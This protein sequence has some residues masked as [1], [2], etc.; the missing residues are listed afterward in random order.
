M[1]SPAYT[2]GGIA[3][4]IGEDGKSAICTQVDF[5]DL[6]NFYAGRSLDGYRFLHNTVGFTANEIFSFLYVTGF[7]LVDGAYITKSEPLIP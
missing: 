7:D 1:S 6:A 5:S 2:H 4:F 3:R